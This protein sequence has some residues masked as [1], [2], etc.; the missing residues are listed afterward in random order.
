M[1]NEKQPTE[2]EVIAILEKKVSNAKKRIDEAYKQ[3]QNAQDNLERQKKAVDIAKAQI[4]GVKKNIAT[5]LA[6]LQELK[7]RVAKNAAV[8]AQQAQ[9]YSFTVNLES[10]RPEVVFGPQANPVNLDKGL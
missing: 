1:I 5:R 4:D 7:E 2:Q 8:Q 10:V 6:A 9:T 3:Y